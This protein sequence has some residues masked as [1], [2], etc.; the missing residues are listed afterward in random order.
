MRT[1]EGALLLL[2]YSRARPIPVLTTSRNGPN[3]LD[4]PVT[5]DFAFSIPQLPHESK[6]FRVPP[7]GIPVL[8]V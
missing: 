2:P 4:D 6:E 7:L 5:F 8:L 3:L 1:I